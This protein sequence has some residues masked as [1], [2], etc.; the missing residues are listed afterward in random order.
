MWIAAYLHLTYCDATAIR[1]DGTFYFLRLDDGTLYGVLGA[2]LCAWLLAL[3]AFFYNIKRSYWATFYST[4]TGCQQ[5]MSYFLENEDNDEKRANIFSDH[6]DLWKSISGDV[7]A[8]TLANWGKWEEEKPA[9]FNESFKES[10]PDKF[11]PKTSRNE[12]GKVRGNSIFGLVEI[13]FSKFI[14]VR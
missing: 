11:I 3:F 7:E 9:W 10:V 13:G 6:S 12:V 4:R 14:Y 8:W 2:L 5:A 1:D